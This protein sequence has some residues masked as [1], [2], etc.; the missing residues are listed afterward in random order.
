VML[1]HDLKTAFLKDNEEFNHNVVNKR[2]PEQEQ[3]P[4]PQ[5]VSVSAGNVVTSMSR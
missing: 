3:Q 4:G 1:Y 2:V 5:S